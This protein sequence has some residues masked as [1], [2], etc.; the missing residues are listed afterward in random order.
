MEKV[1]IYSVFVAFLIQSDAIVA[2]SNDGVTRSDASG[3]I[4]TYICMFLTIINGILSGT[5][6]IKF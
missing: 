2:R 5:R 3:S 6:F 1:K 4:Y